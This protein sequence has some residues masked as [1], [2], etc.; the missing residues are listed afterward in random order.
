MVGMRCAAA[1]LGVCI[2]AGGATGIL[3]QAQQNPVPQAP[4]RGGRGALALLPAS[5]VATPIPS[6]KLVEGPGPVFPGLAPLPAGD[7]LAHFKY[8]VK[9]YFVSGMA[10]GQPYTTRILVRRPS[11]MRKFSGVIVAEA[12][13]PSGNSWMFH[14]THTYVMTQ[15]HASLEIVTGSLPQFV[16][17]NRERYKELNIAP[18]QANEIIAQVGMLMKSGRINTEDGPLAGRPV[19]RMILM[20]TS[21]SAGILTAYLPAHMIYRT[22]DMKP[23]FDG[24][25][26]TSVGGNNPIRPVDVP[27]I[28]I[29]TMTE[30]QAA[31]AS[32]NRYRRPDGDAPG[33]QFRIYEFAGSAHN[34]SRINPTYKPDPCRNPVSRFPLGAMMAVGLDHLIQWADKKKIPPRGEYIAVDGDAKNDGSLLALDSYGNAK[35]GVRNTYVDVPLY[36]YGVPNEAN[37]TPIA[38]PA[39]ILAGRGA[40]FFCSIA[41]Y[42][43]PLSREQLQT[44]YK[45]KKDYQ[46]K[47][48]QRLNQLI[49]AGWFLSMYKNL[50]QEDAAKAVF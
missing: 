8:V 37:P 40:Q 7:D 1:V 18:N 44:L 36:R 45:D 34:D 12:M 30:V 43:T 46:K 14:F 41:G 9:E 26:P 27:V 49:K 23:I 13:H 2:A 38:N 33:D 16:E 22:P 28:Q 10:Q 42:E 5:P 29:P 32:G 25:L 6:F 31:A 20:G 15:G 4:G 48:D 47:V 17:F 35:G 24:F 21:A 3:G 19:R 39:P 50:V 11:D